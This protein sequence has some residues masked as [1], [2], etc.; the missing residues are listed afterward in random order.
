MALKDYPRVHYRKNPLIEVIC[1]VRFPRILSIDGEV[2]SA[3]Q[4]KISAQY[5]ILQTANELQQ[6]FSI[7]ITDDNPVPHITQSERR[8]NYAFMSTDKNWKLSLTSNFLSLSTVKYSSW[9]DFNE[10]LIPIISI[11]KEVYSPSFNEYE[12][13][14]LRYIDGFT[15][16]KLGLVGKDWSELLHPFALGFLSHS[17]IKNDIKSFSC[18][19]EIDAGNQVF[20]RIT[21]A[22]GYVNSG[23]IQIPLPEQE[24][25]LIVDSDIFAFRVNND[26]LFSK[27]D[28]AH[29][30][31][32]NIIQSIITD[33]LQY[34]MGPEKI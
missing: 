19:T 21:T 1:Q 31:S 27:L 8:P 28:Y 3:F 16:S 12:R 32:T 5:P 13:V 18:T 22:L 29:K 7:N 20:A 23:N 10:K 6:Q 24:L 25:S 15:R 26:T 4:N 11:F 30:I 33:T 14:G 2:P 34:A 9:E 17:G